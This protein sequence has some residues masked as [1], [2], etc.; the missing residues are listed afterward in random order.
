MSEFPRDFHIYYTGLYHYYTSNSIYLC[1]LIKV[2]FDFPEHEWN[3]NLHPKA[4]N[5]NLSHFLNLTLQYSLS[6]I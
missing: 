3:I 4:L 5:L 1:Q 2:I 6:D